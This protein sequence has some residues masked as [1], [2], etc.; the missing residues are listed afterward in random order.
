LRSDGQGAGGAGAV[1]SPP[2]V[3]PLS[4]R[5][6]DVMNLVA[7]GRTNGAIAEEL[8]V[9]EKTVKNH[10]NRIYVKLGVRTRAEAIALWL[11][12]RGAEHR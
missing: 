6:L 7:Q 3:S 11:G 4:D 8:F 9:N 2:A 5:E 1:V 10:I 12:V